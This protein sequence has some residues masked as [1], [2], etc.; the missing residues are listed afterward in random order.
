MYVIGSD[1]GLPRRHAVVRSSTR[2]HYPHISS[3]RIYTCPLL[4]LPYPNDIHCVLRMIMLSTAYILEARGL[5]YCFPK[6]VF[7]RLTATQRRR[8]YDG[9]VCNLRAC[10]THVPSDTPTCVL[11]V[12]RVHEGTVA[13]NSVTW[14]TSDTLMAA[15]MHR[16]VSSYIIHNVLVPSHVLP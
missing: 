11:T 2:Y 7:S 5:R 12:V 3:V 4:P 13:V 8:H 16:T 10:S 1:F 9:P 6:V 15:V 14:V